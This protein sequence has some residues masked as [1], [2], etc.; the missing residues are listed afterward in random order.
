MLLLSKELATIRVDVPLQ[1]N[2][3]D[4]RWNVN[5]ELAAKMFEEL[6]FGGLM[7]LIG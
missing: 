3:D 7:K 1:C 5:R 4:C 6:E 2:L